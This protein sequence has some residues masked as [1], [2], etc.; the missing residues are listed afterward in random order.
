MLPS[1]VQPQVART[2]SIG[3]GNVSEVPA[4]G[5]GSQRFQLFAH[6][7]FLAAAPRGR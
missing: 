1:E 5:D 4:A 6:L 2:F 3:E 7:E